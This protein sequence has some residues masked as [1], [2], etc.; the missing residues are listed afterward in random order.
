MDI[1]AVASALTIAGY[2]MLVCLNIHYRFIPV[3]TNQTTFGDFIGEL[4][5]NLVLMAIVFLI[6]Y[7]VVL[8]GFVVWYIIYSMIGFTIMD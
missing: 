3:L 6:M 8:F 5:V 2:M 7:M 1:F 4:V